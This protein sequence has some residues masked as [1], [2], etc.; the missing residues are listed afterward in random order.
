MNSAWKIYLQNCNAIIENDCITHYGNAA[1]EL[2]TTKYSTALVDLS[3]LGLIYFSGEDAE[4]FLQGQLSC[5]VKKIHPYLAQYG[6]YCT[7]KGRILASFL[8]WHDGIN[9]VMQMP[10]TLCTNVKKYLSKFVLRSKVQLIDNSET[11]VRIGISGNKARKL[12]EE[13]LGTIP[14]SHLGIIHNEQESILH[15]GQDRFEI[16]AKPERAP[17]LWEYLSSGAVPVGSPYWDWLEIRAGIPV[18][19]PATQEQFIP[20][21]VNLEM[22]GGVSFQKGCYSGQ[23]IISRTQYLG[24]IK[25]RMYLGNIHSNTPIAAGDE[26]YS[27]EIED[28]PSGIIVNAAPS[29]DGGFDV[30]AVLQISS[31]VAGKVY[32]K[33][34]DGPQLEIIPLPYS[35][36]H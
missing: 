13:I 21:M 29:P 1:I 23:E 36:N 25:R 6:S 2:E 11:L 19:T 12:M 14:D 31:A 35:F 7:P 27:A 10:A 17:K 28:Q 5:D 24:K 15:L 33:T 30:L 8:M 9:Y 18:I 22:I 4:S 32:W 16:I 26:L 20:Q 34:L 3:H